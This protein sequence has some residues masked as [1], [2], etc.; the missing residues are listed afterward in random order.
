MA[1]IPL[2]YFLRVAAEL[3]TTDTDIYTTPTQ[4]ATIVLAANAA[5]LTNDP[6]TVTLNVRSSSSVVATII[7]E[8]IIPPNDAANLI[9]GKLILGVGDVLVAKCSQNNGIELNLSL[10]ESF[11]TPTA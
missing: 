6:V 1:Q 8:F 4:R 5:N 11:N 9:Q 2:N 3:V 10:L 7:K